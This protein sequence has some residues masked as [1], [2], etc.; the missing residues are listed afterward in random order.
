MTAL[1]SLYQVLSKFSSLVIEVKTDSLYF[2]TCISSD[3][4]CTGEEIT[5]ESI[6]IKDVKSFTIHEEDDISQTLSIT[7][8]GYPNIRINCI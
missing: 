4:K 7:F 3:L 8:D 1:E 5:G 2:L 6:T